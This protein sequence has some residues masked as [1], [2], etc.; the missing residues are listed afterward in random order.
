MHTG[1][2]QNLFFS[3]HDFT[4][5]SLG[6]VKGWE[7]T[8]VLSKYGGVK[9]SG[10]VIPLKKWLLCRFIIFFSNFYNGLAQ[11]QK[12][13]RGGKGSDFWRATR[14]TTP[15]HLLPTTHFQISLFSLGLL[16]SFSLNHLN[17]PIHSSPTRYT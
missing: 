6:L 8:K 14:V 13:K 5:Y 17:Q 11:Y 2:S 3:K 10:L 9:N 15:T 16:F 7:L 12:K 4:S 1:H